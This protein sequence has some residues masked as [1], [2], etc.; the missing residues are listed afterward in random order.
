M[1]HPGPDPEPTAPDLIEALA[2]SIARPRSRALLID[3]DN[4]KQGWVTLREAVR[5]GQA[6]AVEVAADIL[7]IDCDNPSLVKVVEQLAVAL[8]DDGEAPAVVASGRPDHRHLF[9]RIGKRDKLRYYQARAKAEGLD[10]R[11]FI[12]PPLAPHRL[13]LP[14]ALISPSDPAAAL[15][16]L[17]PRGGDRPTT[18]QAAGSALRPL[19]AEMT[20]LLHLGDP[21][22]AR[23]DSRSA[24]IQAIATAAVNAGWSYTDFRTALFN[25]GH[26][27]GE[28]VQAMAPREAE[29]YL[30]HSWNKALRHVAKHPAVG[31]RADARQAIASIATAAEVVRW[32][33]RAG[34]TES[35]V[36]LAHI[37]I[38]N[39]AGKLTYHADVRSLADTAG[40]TAPTAARASGRLVK[41]GWLRRTKPADRKKGEATIWTLRTPGGNDTQRNTQTSPTSGPGGTP[42]SNLGSQGG[43]RRRVTESTD[44][45]EV[46]LGHDIFRWGR[47]LGLS[48]R[49]VWRQLHDTE[50]KLVHGLCSALGISK[51]M[52]R[53]HLRRLAGADLAVKTP[54]G[55]L[56]GPGSTE[57]AARARGAH[58]IGARQRLQHQDERERWAER[59]W[60]L[61]PPARR[62]TPEML[63]RAHPSS[64]QAAARVAPRAATGDCA[65]AT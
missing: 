42:R 17:R 44:P 12:R 49:R 45:V 19:S 38:A 29:R 46:P 37:K 31:S 32:P 8:R 27:A 64:Q 53:R 56:R 9:C 35:A 26:I 22:R 47:G 51:Q 60:R 18:Q 30:G 28:K 40:V 52:V 39:K 55:W 57:D 3:A 21:A 43:V 50:P 65:S 11:L 59:A 23:Y 14:V 10:V 4:K 41:A 13:G 1:L 48:T 58:G 25:R 7:A 62:A 15:A 20:V 36:L 24:V 63:P 5:S 2:L 54:T 33:G 6:F 34:A 16:A 61:G